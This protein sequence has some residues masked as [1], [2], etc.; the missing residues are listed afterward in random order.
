MAGFQTVIR[1]PVEHAELVAAVAAL[2]AL[3]NAANRQPSAANV[4]V[5]APVARTR[6]GTEV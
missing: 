3:R 6:K 1:K 2:A 5:H 4:E